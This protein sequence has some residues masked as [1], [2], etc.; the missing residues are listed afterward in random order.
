ML[1]CCPVLFLSE[2][3]GGGT[4]CLSPKTKQMVT[5]DVQPSLLSR[6]LEPSEAPEART[7]RRPVI[8]AHAPELGESLASGEGGVFV[9]DASWPIASSPLHFK[10]LLLES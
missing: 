2:D 1:S 8:H 3:G 7:Q 9:T 10:F 4:F 6:R 5:L